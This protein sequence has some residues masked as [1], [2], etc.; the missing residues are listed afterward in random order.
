MLQYES[1]SF[2]AEFSIY[3]KC[4]QSNYETDKGQNQGQNLLFKIKTS[5]LN[6]NKVFIFYHLYMGLGQWYHGFNLLDYY[7]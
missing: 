4:H 3:E 2:S 5:F 6:Q 7:N 1:C